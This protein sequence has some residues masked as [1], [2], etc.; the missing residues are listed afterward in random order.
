MGK[1]GR[2]KGR[3]G[4]GGSGNIMDYATNVQSQQQTVIGNTI[5]NLSRDT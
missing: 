2:G 3:G 4:G 1:L 5:A